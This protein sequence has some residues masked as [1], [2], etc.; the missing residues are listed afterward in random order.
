MR[1]GGLVGEP[2]RLV[3]GVLVAVHVSVAVLAMVRSASAVVTDDD[4]LR[5]HEIAQRDGTPWRDF[6]VEYAPLE[7]GV[8]LLLGGATPGATAVA[9]V[10]V[11]IVA[12]LATAAALARG[13]SR[14]AAA[15]YLL[16]GLPLLTFIFLRLD[17]IP[18]ALTTLGVLLTRRHRT[19]GPVALAAAAL[20][21]V[22]PV[23]VFPALWF[24]RDRRALVRALGL[25]MAGVALWIVIGGTEAPVQVGSFRGAD[26][27]SVESTVGS[28]VW[29]VTQEPPVL[30][31]GAP[32]VG[33]VPD[34]AR[35]VTGAGA[36]IT[37]GAVWWRARR[38]PGDPAGAPAMVAVAALLAWSPLFSL[39]YALW[40][41]P[42]LAIA[43]AEPAARAG[44]SLAAAAVVGT[45]VV[46]AVAASTTTVEI[47]Q[48]LLLVRNAAVIAVVVWWFAASWPERAVG[49]VPSAR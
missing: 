17:A 46:R 23:V 40:L 30:E 6:E 3:L 26:G 14:G 41:T 12:D 21:K 22:W 19:G 42:F 32:R 15:R 33:T 47:E 5:F 29:T 31:A 18:V 39:Q 7:T 1:F 25:A 20:T 13:W 48:A 27:W 43:A 37:I 45:G 34:A 49:P 8:I 4:V 2:S 28:I 16:V 24:G 36:L 10:I 9:T 11:A 38:Y 35:L 44:A